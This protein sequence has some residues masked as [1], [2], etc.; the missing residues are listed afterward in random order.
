MER[1][2]SSTSRLRSLREKRGM[3]QNALAMKSGI[4]ANR[5]SDTETGRRD[6]LNISLG[7]A[8]KLADALE[9]KDLR[10]LV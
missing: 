4:A 9:V 3:S 1:K 2:D 7:T 6:I 8:I 5:I 10:E